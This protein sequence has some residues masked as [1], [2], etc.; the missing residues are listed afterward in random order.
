[1]K[2]AI[3]IANAQGFWGDSPD[4]PAQ[5][6]QQDPN[7]DFITLDYLAEVSLSIMAIQKEKDSS[8]GYA[9][10]FLEVVNSLIPLWRAGSKTKIVTNAGGLNPLGCACACSH[11]LK[12]ANLNQLKIAIVSGDNVLTELK[13]NPKASFFRNLDTGQELTHVLSQLMTAN[14][15]LGAY[16]IAE[17]IAK[18]ANLV[19]TGRVADP[20]LTVG[21]AIAHFSWK[22]DD[23][24]RLA[25]ATV[26]GHLIECGTQVT[27]GISTDWLTLENV[28]NIGYPI[29]EINEDGSFVITKPANTGGKVDLRTVKEQLLYEIGDPGNY[30]SPDV[31]VSFLKLQLTEESQDRVRVSG[32]VGK[33]PPL[34]L[35]VS[36]SYK[37]GFRAEGTLAFFGRNAPLKAK[38]SGE[39]ILHKLK[40]LNSLPENYKIE[41]LGAGSL[42]PGIF[43][44]KESLECILRVAVADP[45]KN[46]I[47]KFVKQIAP[48]VT[49][50]PQ[51]TTGYISGRPHLRPIFSYW[52]CL[53]PRKEVAPQVEFVQSR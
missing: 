32:A 23:Y 8:L 25:G 31:T 26:A 12:M 14:A 39:I 49:C 33:A 4:A 50:G 24:D 36:A 7:L 38:R 45:Q 15:Y 30:L 1:M 13:A 9:Q 2:R 17:A 37:N 21:P 27:G 28:E 18:G 22:P 40:Q 41:C 16:P 52:P 3:R 46:V 19:I 20:S 44:N 53:I 11:L 47:E 6:M 42:V 29:A 43:E 35:K 34:D 51:G 10:D 5:L 48:L